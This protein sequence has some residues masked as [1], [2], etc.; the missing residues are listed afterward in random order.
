MNSA[1]EHVATDLADDVVEL[2]SSGAELEDRS[3]A[4]DGELRELRPGDVAVLVQTNRTAAPVREA[5]DRAGVPAVINGAGSVFATEIAR[6][7]LRLL[8]ALERPAST[9][10]AAHRRADAASSA[11]R[12]SGSPSPTSRRGRTST[13]GCTTGLG[14]CASAASR[15]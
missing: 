12:P 6:E 10:R 4:E 5:L 8:E 15:R 2:L 1:R 9:I 14:C 13:V 7:W 3:A 11:G